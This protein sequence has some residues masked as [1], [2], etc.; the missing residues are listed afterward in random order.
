MIAIESVE[1]A[2]FMSYGEPPVKLQLRGLGPTLIVGENAGDEEGSSN[3]SGKS[4]LAA[5]ILWCL[6]GRTIGK[7]RPGDAIVNWFNG[8]DCFVKIEVGDY[9]ITRSR[10]LKGSP[11]LIIQKSGKDISASTTENAQKQLL[12]LFNLDYE[13]FVSSVFFGQLGRSFLELPD[14]RRRSILERVFN[15]H[16]LN[17]WAEVAKEK[18]VGLELSVAQLAAE[19]AANES[20]LTRLRADLALKRR[21]ETDYEGRRIDR[22]DA[23]LQRRQTYET[24]LR[25][26]AVPNIPEIKRQWEVVTKIKQKLMEYEAQLTERTAGAMSLKRDIGSI[27]EEEK[28]WKAKAGTMCPSCQQSIAREHVL[29]VC[30]PFDERRKLIQN[31]ITRLEQ[32]ATA[33][34]TVTENTSAKVSAAGPQMSLKEAEAIVRDAARLRDQIQQVDRDVE[35]IMEEDNPYGSQS[36]EKSMSDRDAVITGIKKRIEDLNLLVRHISY[37]HSAYSDK[38]KLKS[39]LL[40]DLIPFLNERVVYYLKAFDCDF[41]MKFDATLKDVT[42]RWDYELCSGG[43]R[44]RIDLA[45]MFAFYDLYVAIY[46]PQCNVIVLDEVDGRLD[47][48][49]VQAF[50]DIIDRDFTSKSGQKN[51]PDA[52]LII[53][54]KDEMRDAFPSKIKVVKDGNISRIVE[55][56]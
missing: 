55:V 38:K 56:R 41:D 15:L 43:E 32:E 21:L 28:R 4:S 6:F 45:V 44:K 13:I 29:N 25:Q 33:I 11:E 23:A 39:F 17:V 8:K 3:G 48:S 46:G 40:S 35:T 18:L 50:V 24:E 42:S 53:S 30:A 52:V 14:A 16:R 34:R 19:C 12:R 20:E 31:Q 27:N 49:G 1:I 26:I 5:A 7:D 37:L 54:H 22:R 2:N 36:A 47:P 9:A 10:R 51:R